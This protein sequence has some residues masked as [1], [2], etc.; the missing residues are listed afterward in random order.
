MF[1]PLDVKD[2]WGIVFPGPTISRFIIL[3]KYRDKCERFR[4]KICLIMARQ[5][6]FT[7]VKIPKARFLVFTQSCTSVMPVTQDH[8]YSINATQDHKISYY[9]STPRNMTIRQQSNLMKHTVVLGT[10][11]FMWSGVYLYG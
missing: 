5:K 2:K 6:L 7:P 9:D 3:F 4:P 11:F 1:C 10:L 8:F